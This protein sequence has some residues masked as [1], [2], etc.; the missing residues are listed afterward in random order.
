MSKL[1]SS[2][3]LQ[4]ASLSVHTLVWSSSSLPRPIATSQC[5]IPAEKKIKWTQKN[6]DMLVD[7]YR[8][9]KMHIWARKEDVQTYTW[10][11]L[12]SR[13]SNNTNKTKHRGIF[14]KHEIDPILRSYFFGR[15]WDL[16]GLFLRLLANE[17]HHLLD[18]LWNICVIHFEWSRNRTEE[19]Q[20]VLRARIGDSEH[21]STWIIRDRKTCKQCPYKCFQNVSRHDDFY[22]LFSFLSH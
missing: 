17:P 14:D 22:G 11:K 4:L 18:L 7:A 5:W 6:I 1:T 19:D 8:N 20:R 15:N 2:F 13:K 16:I 12:N 21:S 9:T 10:I 3:A